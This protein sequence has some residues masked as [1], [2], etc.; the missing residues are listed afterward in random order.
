MS[1]LR[2]D[3]QPSLR[4]PVLIAA[5][6]GWN[7]AAQAASSSILYLMNGWSARS[8]ASI[9][10][11]EF[12]DFTEVRPVIRLGPGSQRELEWPTNTFYYHI[13]HTL[14][15]DVALLLGIEPHLKWRTFT[16]A[17]LEVIRQCG[18]T[19]LITLGALLADAVHTRPVPLS[20]YSMDRDL[21]VRLGSMRIAGTRYQGPT[22]IV[23][24]LH[25]ACRRNG[26][27]AASLWAS[28]PYYL[29]TTPNP[30]ASH[31]LLSAASDL[32]DLH[33]DLAPLE[34]QVRA[35]EKQVGE[36]VSSN[37]DV[38]AH[39]R[40]LEARIDAALAGGTEAA[41]VGELPASDLIIKDLEDFLRSQRQDGE[42]D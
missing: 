1:H 36:A 30:K 42:E 38:A 33:V 32:L 4:S 35:F 24:T 20:G 6:A 37:P 7:D 26:L 34:E 41:E 8:F 28:V 15:Q 11:E 16:D 3:E 19:T 18:V 27:P 12:Y 21:S 2:M 29:G 5:F 9:D 13:D 31:A 10:P 39:I 23:G 40:E 17:V 25:D 22:G 14:S